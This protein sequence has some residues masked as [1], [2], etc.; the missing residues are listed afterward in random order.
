MSAYS[1]NSKKISQFTKGAA[2]TN[3]VQYSSLQGGIN[4][5][6]TQQQ[7]IDDFQDVYGA[8]LR[9]F[10]FESELVASDIA[11]GEN[12]IVEENNYSFYKITNA[13]AV[14]D[15]IELDS[16]LVATFEHP[17]AR[18]KF[19]SV[20]DMRLRS[21]EAGTFVTTDGYYG[22]KTAGGS[23]YLI[24]TAAEAATDG[25][26]VDEYG[27]HTLANGNVAILQVRKGKF[28][29]SKFGASI[30]GTTTQNY[31][32]ITACWSA[33]CALGS[34]EIVFDGLY[35][36]GSN[37]WVL[38]PETNFGSRSF[39][40]IRGSSSIFRDQQNTLSK[41]GVQGIISSATTCIRWGGASADMIGRGNVKNFA[42]F[43]TGTDQK[44]L[45]FENAFGNTNL[46]VD[47]D[48]VSLIDFSGD[49][50]MP[51]DQGRCVDTVWNRLKMFGKGV[52]PFCG[53]YVTREL[54]TLIAPQF[55]YCGRSIYISRSASAYINVIGGWSI[56]PLQAHIEFEGGAVTHVNRS[57][58]SG[59]SMLESTPFA[60]EALTVDTPGGCTANISFS[61]CQFDSPPKI[62]ITNITQANPAVVTSVGHTAKDGQLIRI[63]SVSGM[64]E[65]NGNNYTVT[66][67]DND[68]FSIGVDSTGYTAYT[69]G[70]TC[71][72][73]IVNF[74]CGG[75]LGLF[76]V[77]NTQP[78][79][80][81]KVKLGAF[82]TFT[83][84][85]CEDFQMADNTWSRAVSV[86]SGIPELGDSGIGAQGLNAEPTSAKN[87]YCYLDS[88]S[89]TNNS[90]AGWRLYDAGSAGYI[91]M[92]PSTGST[93]GAGSAGAGNQYLELTTPQGVTYRV[94]H[95]G[96]V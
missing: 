92:S 51:I 70:G 30:S 94:L 91:D 62:N 80:A 31:D 71:E 84:V 53:I 76:G 27:N 52:Q 64:T 22:K 15:D 19:D 75:K 48:N 38:E 56:L 44:G 23:K 37:V 78:S 5:T 89:N 34:G 95:D 17:S 96:T 79:H 68:T 49:A 33:L 29:T 35:D 73:M 65:V 67:I 83:A 66:V 24:K 13:A 50:A 93:G 57:T 32:A 26:L 2:I 59:F 74:Q 46:T 54:P 39:Y 63:A 82:T 45:D 88:G 1:N 81:N 69:S 14:L 61:N 8:S 87:G 21:L 36:V 7:I 90:K 20:A 47:L 16:G 86:N 18:L 28:V 41:G 9:T 42:V 60:T 77:K 43:A 55:N 6:F 72:A 85:S 12:A 10:E 3:D 58:V 25:D 40:E 4:K 11:L